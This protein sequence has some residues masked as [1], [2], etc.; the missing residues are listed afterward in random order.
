MVSTALIFMIIL[1]GEKSFVDIASTKFC[2]HR[3]KSVEITLKL[4][5][6]FQ[7]KNAAHCNYFRE[8][9]KYLTALGG[10]FV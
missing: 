7:V 4:Q 8:C 6:C 2:L 5:W 3:T 10:Y 9:Y 1:I